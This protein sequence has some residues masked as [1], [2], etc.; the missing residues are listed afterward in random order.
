MAQKEIDQTFELLE[1]PSD[2]MVYT[3]VTVSV[4]AQREA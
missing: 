3:P 1:R 2:L 4:W